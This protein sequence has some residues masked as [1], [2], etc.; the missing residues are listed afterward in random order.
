MTWIYDGSFEGFL[1]AVIK[2]YREKML[3]DLLTKTP[4]N[5]GLFD[6]IIEVVNVPEDVVKLSQSIRLQ[7]GQKIEERIFHTFLCDD[8]PF[9]NDLLRY[10][11]LGLKDPMTLTL[12][13]HP[14]V[15]AIEIYQRR[16]LRALHKMNAYLRFESLDEG[17]L[18]A[19]ISP[20]CNTLPLMGKSFT[21]RLRDEKF[22]IH[23]LKRARALIYDGKELHIHNLH[24]IDLPQHSSDELYYQHLWKRFFDSVAI[25]ERL[26]PKLQRQHVP[27]YYREYMCE[28]DSTK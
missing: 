19:K 27:L 28:F 17:T 20:P 24:A 1:S 3:P 4:P 5:E 6:E 7:L 22:I 8:E 14:T 16:V 25:T 9:E 18:Y 13:S 23:D 2:S 12:L 26:N 21:N 15:Y 10:I 11:R